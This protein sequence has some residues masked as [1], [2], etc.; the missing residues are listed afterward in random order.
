MTALVISGMAIVLP[1][2]ASATTN[3]PINRVR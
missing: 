2:E 1:M 3:M